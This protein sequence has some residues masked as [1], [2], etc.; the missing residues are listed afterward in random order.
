MV[1][2]S[3]ITLGNKGMQKFFSKNET[4][5]MEILWQR[6]ECTTE[7]IG[8][9]LNKSLGCISGTLDRLVKSGFANRRIDAS[10]NK[11]RYIYSPSKSKDEV[12]EVITEKIAENL[13]ETFGDSVVNTFGKFKK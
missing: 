1:K 11:I 12:G 6:K 4:K 13:I 7:E 8:K 2:I 5:I 9:S 10:A 3:R